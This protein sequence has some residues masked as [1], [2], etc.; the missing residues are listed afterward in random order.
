MKE[1]VVKLKF[2]WANVWRGVSHLLG[3]IF[4][5][6]SVGNVQRYFLDRSYAPVDIKVLEEA[7]LYVSQQ[8]KEDGW[9]YMSE[10]EDC[11]NFANYKAAA[12]IHYLRDKMDGNPY[13]SVFCYITEKGYGHAI[14][15]CKT[16]EGVKYY[17]PQWLGD[18]SIVPKKLSYG[19]EKRIIYEIV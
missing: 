7:L 3:A 8:M 1:F 2:W 6:K 18:K 14:I 15:K 17:E 13:V 16:S 12:V 10:K 5:A 9:Q 11:D 4:R 19:E